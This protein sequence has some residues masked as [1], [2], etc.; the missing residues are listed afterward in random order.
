MGRAC[1]SS[2]TG[3]VVWTCSRSRRTAAIA[4]HLV[5]SSN[6]TFIHPDWS[7]DGRRLLSSTGRGDMFVLPRAP[8]AR[9]EASRDRGRRAAGAVRRRTRGGLPTCRTSRACQRSTY[10][11]LPAAGASAC[12]PDGGAQPRWRADGK[13]LFSLAPDGTLMAAAVRRS[14]DDIDPLRQP[15]LFNTRIT[16]GHLDRRNQY[17]S[18]ATVSACSSTSVR[19]MRTPAPITVVVNCELTNRQQP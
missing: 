3:W 18:P 11:G 12:Q 15:A 7:Q 17:S 6:E 14:A 10:D 5:L 19:R 13:E 16:T 9:P 8:G 2:R 1:R 4:K